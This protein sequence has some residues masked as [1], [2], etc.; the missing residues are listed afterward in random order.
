MQTEFLQLRFPARLA[1][2]LALTHVQLIPMDSQRLLPDHTIVVADG[3]IAAIGPSSSVDV[4]GMRVVDGRGRY[5]MPG[6]ADMY[7]H[8]RDPHEAPLY[9]AHGITCTRTSGNLFQLALERSAARGDF[10]SP[11]IATVSPTIDGVGPS[12][13]T[14][15]PHGVPLTQPEEAE[16]LVQ[17]Y[18]RRGYHQITPFSLLTPGNLAAIGRASAA[19]GVA[20]VG[21]CPNSTSWEEAVEAGMNGFQQLHLIARDH[22]LAEFSGQ[23]YWDRFDPAPGT[24]LDFDSIRRLAH[25]LAQRQVWSIPTVVFHQRAS[26]PLEESMADPTLR[27]VPQSTIDDWE[28]TIVRWSHRGRVSVEEWR[29]LARERARAFERVVSIFDEEGAPQLTGT[30]SLNPYNVQGD[31]L[32]QELENFVAAGMRPFEALRCAT[33][34]AARFL[35]ETARWGT[36]EVGKRGDVLLLDGNPLEDIRAVRSVQAVSVNGYY[37]ERADLNSLL[38]QRVQMINNPPPIPSTALPVM[39]EQGGRVVGEGAWVERIVDA[40]FGRFSYRHTRLPDGDWL[41]EESH[42]GADPRRNLDRRT[43]RLVLAPDL[44]V[45]S[46]EYEV[47]SFVGSETARLSWSEDEG[48]VVHYT[49]VDDYQSRRSLAG[50][51]RVPSEQLALSAIPRLIT[52]RGSGTYAALDAEADQPGESDLSITRAE[53]ANAWRLNVG[54]VGQR[55]EQTYRLGSD[56]D[57]VQMDEMLPLLWPREIAPVAGAARV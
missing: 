48:Y 2:P 23:D 4:Q 19:A 49:A 38:E 29:R 16:P 30:D 26:R 37:L 31:S 1:Q 13:K 15:M 36:L 22:M 9:L 40:E 25:L 10:P 12:G 7:S 34:E 28:S 52:E 44:T 50:D 46:G 55:V 5:A 3:T 39:D 56:A 57:L 24:R 8:Y 20:M 45:R 42:A 41:L 47:E 17:R 11:W 35:G 51:R 43:V 32:H 53:D 18:V 6:L 33:T 21:N 54:R 27:Y 14:D